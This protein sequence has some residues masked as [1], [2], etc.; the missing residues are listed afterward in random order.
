[1]A[2]ILVSPS[3]AAGAKNGWAGIVVDGAVRDVAELQAAGVGI[4]ARALC[5]MPPAKRGGGHEGGPVRLQGV[6]VN[7]GDWLYADADGIVVSARPLH[8]G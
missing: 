5:P 7:P 1:M 8:G 3:A 4:F 6:V 2:P